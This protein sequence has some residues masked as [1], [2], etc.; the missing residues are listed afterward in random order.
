MYT[1]EFLRTLQRELAEAAP[2]GTVL[3][4]GSY[5]YGEATST[6]DVDFY[7]IC[8]WYKLFSYHTSVRAWKKS[9]SNLQITVMVVPSFALVSGW[10]YVYGETVEGQVITSFFNKNSIITSALILG[11]FYWL[12][13]HVAT[14]QEEKTLAVVSL[15][16][17]ISFIDTACNYSKN[18]TPALCWSMM[19]RSVSKSSP[20]AHTILQARMDG[21]LKDQV[22]PEDMLQTLS[23]LYEDNKEHVRFSLTAYLAYNALAIRH[24]KWLF[25]FGNPATIILLKIRRGLENNVEPSKLY[26]EVQSIIYPS[27]VL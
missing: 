7:I 16:K 19:R 13:Y 14:T 3:L 2:G 25:L 20:W 18:D 1:R 8:P 12:K 9:H 15:A 26:E 17:K 10:Y 23:K 27:V 24:G 22:M 11:Y 6:S 21:T 4:G 5:A